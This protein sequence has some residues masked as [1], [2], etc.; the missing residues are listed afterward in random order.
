[1]V[2][3]LWTSDYSVGVASL[4]ADHITVA[5]VINRLHEV[6]QFGIDE[7]VIGGILKV[8]IDH[9][10]THFQREEELLEKY[11]YPELEQHKKEHRL[12]TEQLEKLHEAYQSTPDPDISQ[13]IIEL[14]TFGFVKHIL[15]V[16]MRYK[17][18]LQEAMA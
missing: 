5:S 2:P 13:E 7:A 15:E 18:Y 14:L 11:G 1:M 16:D 4:D 9:A 12:I 3:I 8:V 6:K 17:A 10:H